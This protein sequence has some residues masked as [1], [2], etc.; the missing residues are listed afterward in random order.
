MKIAFGSCFHKTGLW[1]RA[2]LDRIGSRGNKAMLVLG[3]AAVDDRDNKVGMHRCDYLLRDL[4]PGWRA[5][6]ARVPVYATWDDHD[7]F[8]NDKSGIPRR[9]TAADRS[10]VRTVWTQ[11]WNN[12]SFGFAE[13]EEGIFFRTRIGPCDVIM[14]D[15]RYFRTTPN[16]KDA[17]LGVDQMRW[18]EQE[19]VTC[20]GPF[21]ILTSGTM[22]SDYVSN[23][24]DSWGKWDKPGREKVFS[25]IERRGI[26]GVLLLSGYRHGARVVKIPRPSGLTLYEFELG[27][28]GA[29]PGPGAMGNKP[30]LQPFGKTVTFLFGEFTFDTSRADPTVT[31]RAID[32]AGKEHFSVTLSRSQLTPPDR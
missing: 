6:V 9:Y 26:A 30:D 10:G 8:N 4:S 3:D 24:K 27:S 23:G 12:P 29:H 28:L 20:K 31:M 16:E 5:L 25:L 22:W 13:R 18:L 17:Y 11:N 32:P 21:V 15:T 2:L 7:Y 1:N 19:L 14:L